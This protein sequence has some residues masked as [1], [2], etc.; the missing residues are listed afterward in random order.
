MVADDGF[1]SGP[2]GVE[3]P[4]ARGDYC[5][6][7]FTTVNASC[8]LLV[9]VWSVYGG[10]VTSGVL[11]E[12]RPRDV[13]AEV[14]CDVE[15]CRSVWTENPSTPPYPRVIHAV[16]RERVDLGEVR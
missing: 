6:E 2:D 16:L 8:G 15:C 5:E 7:A 10:A 11:G 3:A 4:L 9:D 12:S 1:W 14:I 13:V